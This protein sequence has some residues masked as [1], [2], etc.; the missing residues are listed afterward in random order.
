MSVSTTQERANAI[1]PQSKQTL[2]GAFAIRL[3][4]DPQKVLP[5][6]RE[7]IIPGGKASDEQIQVFLSV[8]NEYELN[9]FTKEIY[10]FPTK[11]GGVQPIVGV[12]GWIKLI[13]RQSDLNGLEFVEEADEDGKPFSATCRIFRK[14]MERCIAI[15][16]YYS[17]CQRNT[18]P[19]QKWPRRMLRHKAM[20]QCARVAFGFSG[21]VDEDEADRMKEVNAI[22]VETELPQRTQE[23]RS[24]LKDGLA[25][26]RS[27]PTS[28]S[29]AQEYSS[30]P[31]QQPE[32]QNDPDPD[33]SDELIPEES[34]A[35]PGQQTE[36]PAAY[37]F[38]H[39]RYGEHQELI[40]KCLKDVGLPG[41]LM[42][43]IPQDL[44]AADLNKLNRAKG[45]LL[46]SLSK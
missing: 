21:I 14:S 10:A 15:T 26:T 33:V 11:G 8:S 20:I 9:P 19:W 22:V 29:P 46:S 12:D 35:E 6:L 2:I 36:V 34:I 24:K 18:E 17:E 40:D 38:L 45:K 16:E 28:E 32:P 43:I 42:A 7:T 3:G 44:N 39:E 13:H 23:L 27:R 37:M 30:Q 5:V 1:V 31:E 25:K 4:L 41:D